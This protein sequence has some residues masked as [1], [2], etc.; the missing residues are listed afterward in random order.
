MSCGVGCRHGSDPALLWLWCRLVAT[1]PFGPRAWEPPYAVGA[2]QEMAKRQTHTK[3]WAKD[4][5]RY[6]SE[7]DIRR[8]NKDMKRCATSLA[9]KEMQIKTTMPYYFTSTRMAPIKNTDKGALGDS[10][11]T[12]TV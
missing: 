5:N 3:N 9:M 8:A 4:L 7:K 12:N 2:A 10:P 11:K 6:F 1:A